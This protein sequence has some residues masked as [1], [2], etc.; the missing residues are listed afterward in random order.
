QRLVDIGGMPGSDIPQGQDTYE[1]VFT[2]IHYRNA[3]YLRVGHLPHYFVDVL[4]LEAVT[5][6]VGHDVFHGGVSRVLPDGG[7]S[8]RN[9]AIGDHADQSLTLAHRQG[10]DIQ[11]I[12]QLR[13]TAQ[14]FAR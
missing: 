13:C 9:V 1:P 5:H 10:T 6:L 2:P 4:V 12:H 11:F 8:H 3:A 14:A 7:G